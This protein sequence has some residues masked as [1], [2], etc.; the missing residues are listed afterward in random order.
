MGL[1]RHHDDLRLATLGRPTS[2]T[3]DLVM[4]DVDPVEVPNG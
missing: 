2:G 1:E 4:A 3:E